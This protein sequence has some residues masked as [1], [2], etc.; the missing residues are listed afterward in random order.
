[1]SDQRQ[2]ISELTAAQR[3]FLARRLAQR[4]TPEPATPPRAPAVV[5]SAP[6]SFAQE[7]MW[8]RHLLVPDDAAHN[9]AGSLRLRGQVSTRALNDAFSE[10]VRRH[11]SLRTN[12]IVQDGEPL[13]QIHPPFPFQ[14]ELVDLTS[15]PRSEGL[16]E[17][18]RLYHRETVRS[19]DL[20]RERLLRA[21]LLQLTPDESLLLLTVHHIVADGWSIGLLLGE[22]AELYTAG[23]LGRAPAVAPLRWQYREFAAWQRAR[24]DG[25]DYRESLEYWR[26]QLADPPVVVQLRPDAAGGGDARHGVT[27]QL[28]LERPLRAE[29]E[30]LGRDENATLFVVLLTAFLVVLRRA[31]GEEDLIVGTPVSG[32]TRV[33]SEPLIGLFV[34]TVALRVRLPADCT[35]RLAL[36]AA[37]QTTLDALDHHEVP[38]ERVVR[39]VS[40]ERRASR[41]PWFDI[42]FNFTPSPPQTLELPNLRATFE[43][44]PGQG[45]EFSMQLF[46]TER[47]GALDLKLLYPEEV[48]SAARMTG[49]LEQFKAVITQATRHPGA[50]LASFDL[51]TDGMR[52]VLPNP[53]APLAQPSHQSILHNFRDWVIQA[54]DR[55]SIESEDGVLTFAQL[56]GSMVKIAEALEARGM[57]PGDVVAVFGP[58]SAS[59]VV[60]ATG[61]LLAGGILL[62]L[63]TDLPAERRR[64]M[65]REA[66][67]RFVFLLGP[68]PSDMA[69]TEQVAVLLEQ[70]VEERASEEVRA[71]IEQRL[72]RLTEAAYLFFTSGSTGKPKAVLGTHAGLAHFLAWQRE[73]F[74]VGPT[75]R[76]GHL[77]GLSFD[78]VLRDIF[79]PLSSGATLV[80]PAPA[81]LEVPA[82]T[83]RWL[84]RERIT[85]IHT[86]PALADAWLLS[87]PPEVALGSLAR[88]FFAGEPL[89]STLIERWRSA[90]PRAGEIVNL[91]GPTETTLAKCYY[92]VPPQLRAGI[93]PL[94]RPLPQTQALVLTP[95]RR[96]C[97]VGE[98]GEIAIRTPFR[99]LGYF[100]APEENSARFV[101]NPYSPDSG[102]LLYLTGDRGAYT[103]EGLLEFLGRLDDQVK[104]RG[105]RVEPAEVAATLKSCPEVAACAV[106]CRRDPVEGPAL[107]AYVVL[108]AGAPR[109][110]APLRAFMRLHLAAPMQPSAIVFLD[111]LPLTPNHKLDRRRLPEP[112]PERALAGREYVA[113]R[114]ET[115]RQLVQI[116]EEILPVRPI[117]IDDDFF[118]LGGH[119]LLVFRLLLRAEQALGVKVPMAAFF[120][121]ST[122]ARMASSIQSA[123]AN[124]SAVVELRPG[125][126]RLKLFLVHPGGG[127][128]AGYRDL[129]RHLPEPLAV[130]GFQPSG[131]DGRPPHETIE[132]M[133]ACYLAE[134]RR[135]QPQ[136]PYLLAGHSLGGVIAFEMARQ[137]VEHGDQI[138]LLAMFDSASPRESHAGTPSE[139]DAA[140]VLAG[141]VETVGRF[142]GRDLGLSA[143]ALA[144]LSTDEQIAAVHR[145]TWPFHSLLGG[146]GEAFIA[147]MFRLGQ[148]H[149][150]ARDRYGPA[151][152]AVP[153]TFYQAAVK[154]IDAQAWGALSTLPITI[155]DAPGDHVTMMAE[156]NVADLAGDLRAR[157]EKVQRTM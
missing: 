16:E 138:A 82:A 118:A 85:S 29:I 154:G 99:S 58:R 67:A 112:P 45:A 103:A 104:I 60:A 44:P 13:Q 133:A 33:E 83:L 94:G 43:E 1:M 86:V 79:L 136:G 146:E 41:H 127:T 116:W 25:A 12:F 14:L 23:V 56:G 124:S 152:T 20:E 91:Y 157:L 26:R 72:P 102:D 32:R 69:W 134:L 81:D 101:P 144:G 125:T 15:L 149:L 90:F 3:D 4:R 62:T 117:G 55:A 19:F 74:S 59:V 21:S 148:A 96:L 128:V 10:I 51:V 39:E 66:G 47:E 31:S 155:V 142:V 2:R 141:M 119:S 57:Q 63:S 93:Q 153:I 65:L 35:F 48:Y 53:A 76:C 17:C 115:E 100:N 114:T 36:A 111:A 75:D 28:T 97:G 131:L 145:A 7:R 6:L 126:S 11:E 106:I 50:S 135:L 89:T 130:Y 22:L 24:S 54:P 105:V 68:K 92:C 88:L 137:L 98:P 30:R 121:H 95:D 120:E 80:I 70:Q 5:T 150:R 129:V 77:T 38:F 64:V 147:N 49:F 87:P 123:G 132:E 109:D 37:R 78:V 40:P 8:F 140:R 27:A 61:V 110:P 42:L 9:L 46:I 18:L 107:V 151:P 156:P 143:E 108:E 73:T 113:P 52:R 139:T 84:E 122:I 34:N 71:A